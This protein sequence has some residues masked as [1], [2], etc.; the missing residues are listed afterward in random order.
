MIHVCL[1]LN[2]PLERRWS[3]HNLRT[4][5]ESNAVSAVGKHWREKHFHTHVQR[6]CLRQ[7]VARFSLWRPWF[8]LPVSQSVCA[9]WLT[10]WHRDIFS[11]YFLFPCEDRSTNAPYSLRLHV[12]L[13]RMTNGW[14]LGSFIKQSSFL[15]W[16]ALN[17]T[18]K[19]IFKGLKI[20]SKKWSEQT[21]VTGE[22]HEHHLLN[23][24]LQDEFLTT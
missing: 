14:S 7:L 12:A 20:V 19:K 24:K 5:K 8:D 13:T 11:L 2:S 17:T 4:C 16:E 1:N 23:Q 21:C 3:G 15:N 9:M 6:L 10:K 18:T 22:H